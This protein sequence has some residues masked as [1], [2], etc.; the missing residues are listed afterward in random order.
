VPSH[1]PTC[2]FCQGSG[3]CHRCDGTGF[4]RARRA[5]PQPCHECNGSGKCDL[6]GGT[7]LRKEEKP[8]K[9]RQG[10]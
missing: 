9:G 6:C 10:E 1:P 2:P 3:L 5:K 4:I 8:G 7:G